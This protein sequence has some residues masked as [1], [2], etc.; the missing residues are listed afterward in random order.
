[1]AKY[2]LA[3]RINKDSNVWQTVGTTFH[4][5]W[6]GDPRNFFASCGW[7]APNVFQRMNKEKKDFPYLSGRKIGP[8]WLRMLRENVGIKL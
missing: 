1:M 4:T 5:K 2:S 7:S 6:G 3:Q 8:L